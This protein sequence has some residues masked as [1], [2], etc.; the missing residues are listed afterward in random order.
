MVLDDAR[1]LVIESANARVSA[2]ERKNG[3]F[4]WVQTDNALPL[5]LPLENEMLQFVLGISDLAAMDQQFLRVNGLSVQNYTLKIDGHIIA[6]FTRE[7][8]AT[9]VNL[10]LYATPMENHAKDVDG[11]ALKRTQL[12][13][14]SFILII[15]DPK[16]TSDAKA[17]EAIEA[18]ERALQEEERKASQPHPHTFELL[19]E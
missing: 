1:L 15:D 12:G 11:M 16:S 9:G 14:A 8:L 4:S 5:P 17:T 2:L 18:K 10:A 6:S 7:Q 13:E 19:P 3:G